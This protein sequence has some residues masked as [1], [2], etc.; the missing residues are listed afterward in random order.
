MSEHE[1]NERVNVSSVRENR[2]AITIF[3][4]LN[5]QVNVSY[6]V[7][8]TS[9]VCEVKMETTSVCEN[10]KAIT[11]VKQKSKRHLIYM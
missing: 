7:V 1:L 5:E 11:E 3:I 10:R 6:F 8:N 2:Q 4:H 9:V